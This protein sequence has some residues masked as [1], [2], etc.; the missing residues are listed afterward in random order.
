VSVCAGRFT[1]KKLECLK[2]APQSRNWLCYNTF[3][4]MDNQCIIKS[5]PAIFS[6]KS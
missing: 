1:L 5:T 2:Q 4:A 3:N 6:F